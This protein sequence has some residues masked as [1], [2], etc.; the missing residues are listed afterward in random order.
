MVDGKSRFDDLSGVKRRLEKLA[1]EGRDSELIELVLELL[2]QVRDDNTR[3]KVRLQNALRALYGR[4][5]EKVSSDQLALLF[6]ELGDEV[7]QGARDVVE[8]ATKDDDKGE[9]A[10]PKKAPRRRNGRKPL[11]D[12]L[13]REQRIIVVQDELRVCSRCGNDKK[14]FGYIDS[15]ILEFVPAHFKIIEEKRE[16]LVCEQCGNGVVVAP[17]EKPMERGRP[18]PGLLADIVVHKGQDSLPLYRQSQIYKRYGVSISP[19]TI[20]EWHGF[21]CDALEP[22]ARAIIARVLGS[23]VIQ[24]DDTGLKVLDRKHPKGIKLG[25]MWAYVGDGDLVAFDYTPTWEA[26]GPI[27]FLESFNGYLQGD[28]YAGFKTLLE[29]QRGDPLISEDRRLGCAMHIRRKF[30]QAKDAGDARGAIALAFF[31]RL[32]DVE[33]QCK[34]DKLTPAERKLRRDEESLPV[35]DELYT[36]IHE[37]HVTL[38]PDSPLY[39]ATRYAINQEP[40]FRF[41]FTDGRFE[42]DNGEVERQLRRVAIGRKNYLFAGSDRGAERL[43]IAYTVLG[44]CHMKNID[45]L[46]YITDVIDKVQNGWPKSRLAELLPDAW[47]PPVATTA[48]MPPASV[49]VSPNTVAAS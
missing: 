31:R 8:E 32:Y 16:K 26:E 12:N 4:K 6:E 30:E 27:A 19:A 36:W 18:G 29:R 37:T 22:I 14:C 42:I 25:H 33:R 43:A 45:P 41:C 1:K 10:Q 44:S 38:V 17:T 24:A 13:P 40:F 11:P 39:K 9:V 47:Q 46:A 5:S 21:T 3:L 7:P 15:E 34:K 48:P 49:P 20:G 23:G 35:L 2:M 28:G